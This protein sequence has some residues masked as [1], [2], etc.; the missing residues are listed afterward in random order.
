M[1]RNI[2]R[3]DGIIQSPNDPRLHR[4]L[5]LENGLQ[6]VLISDP[7]TDKAAA[8]MTVAVGKCVIN[9]VKEI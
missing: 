8:C 5:K 7:K 2:E 3:F 9:G 4:A 1:S 6:I